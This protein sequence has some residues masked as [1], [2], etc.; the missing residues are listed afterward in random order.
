MF[1][2][3]FIVHIRNRQLALSC[4]VSCIGW[5]ASRPV[6]NST[7]NS[8]SSLATSFCIIYISGLV[9]YPPWKRGDI[10]LSLS[11]C[12]SVPFDVGNFVQTSFLWRSHVR[13]LIFYILKSCNV[14]VSCR[15]TY[16]CRNGSTLKISEK[17]FSAEEKWVI[18]G[19]FAI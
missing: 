18:I 1:E 4:S 7:V 9:S 14:K 8:I 10:G 19:D 11:V 17:Y 2:T 3:P 13:A 15:S 5:W 12:P 6:S 16:N